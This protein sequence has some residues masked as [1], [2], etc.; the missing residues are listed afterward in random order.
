MVPLI[1]G[2]PHISVDGKPQAASVSILEKTWPGYRVQR[3]RVRVFGLRV[4][5]LML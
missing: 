2:N 4:W 1:V 3:L 5:G